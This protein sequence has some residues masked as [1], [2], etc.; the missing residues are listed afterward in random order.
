[1]FENIIPP[2]L[3]LVVRIVLHN[4]IAAHEEIQFDRVCCFCSFN[5]IIVSRGFPSESILSIVK[6]NAGFQINN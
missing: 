4:Y 1:M 6:I 3:V 2:K 5:V